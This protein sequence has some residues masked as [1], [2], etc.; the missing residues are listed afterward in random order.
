MK[1]MVLAVSLFLS[2]I[3]SACANSLD[4]ALK[5]CSTITSAK[6]TGSN[7]K[8]L[9]GWK[10]VDWSDSHPDFSKY[11]VFQ[12]MTGDQSFEA[13]KPWA[14]KAAQGF[15]VRKEDKFFKSQTGDFLW[16]RSVEQKQDV[17]ALVATTNLRSDLLLEKF[18]AVCRGWTPMSQLQV[19]GWFCSQARLLTTDRKQRAVFNL[20]I[21]HSAELATAKGRPILFNM[22]LAK[23]PK[24]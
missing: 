13:L 2:C 16:V 18:N 11:L 22:R 6:G 7:A 9:S 21:F 20:K 8:A 23:E 14:E 10:S 15:P 17:C 1:I 24:G 4:A 19:E 12:N 3:G 5:L